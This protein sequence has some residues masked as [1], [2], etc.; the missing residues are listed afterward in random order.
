MVGGERMREAFEL[1]LYTA[2]KILKKKMRSLR[3]KILEY[4]FLI[5]KKNHLF[6]K[7]ALISVGTLSS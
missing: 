4:S 3:N 1:E 6:L 5:P 2:L 7:I